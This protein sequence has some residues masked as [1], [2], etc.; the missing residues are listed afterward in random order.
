MPAITPKCLEDTAQS[1][2]ILIR[3]REKTLDEV[4]SKPAKVKAR[5]IELLAQP[6]E[7]PET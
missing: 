4:P 7:E 2:A 1:Y 6:I 5:V 3:A